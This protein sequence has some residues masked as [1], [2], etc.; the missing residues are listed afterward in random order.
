MFSYASELTIVNSTISANVA[1]TGGGIYAFRDSGPL[2][3]SIEGST[4][5]G[6]SATGD[7]GGGGIFGS[8][9]SLAIANSTISGNTTNGRGG[10]VL[11]ELMAPFP[12]GTR[13]SRPIA[14]AQAIRMAAV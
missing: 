6:N 4:I 8:S 7:V 14:V 13:R 3:T 11:S 10:G 12:F 9:G 2:S 5:S 1:Q